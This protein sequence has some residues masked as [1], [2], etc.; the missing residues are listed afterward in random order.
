MKMLKTLECQGALLLVV[1][2]TWVWFIGG[3]TLVLRLCLEVSIIMAF[4]IGITGILIYCLDRQRAKEEH[5]LL[6]SVIDDGLFRGR[7]SDDE[8]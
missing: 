7:E 4:Y 3:T 2:V 5:E 8:V 1:S 6:A